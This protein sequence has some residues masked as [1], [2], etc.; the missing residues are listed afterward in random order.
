[1]N[2]L[3]G[4][5]ERGELIVK[6]ELGNI[7]GATLNTVTDKQELLRLAKLGAIADEGIKECSGYFKECHDNYCGYTEFCP[8]YIKPEQALTTE[9]EE[10]DNG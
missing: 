4:K 1:M 8:S 2:D 5:I 3:I 10:G 6:L 9:P 7:V